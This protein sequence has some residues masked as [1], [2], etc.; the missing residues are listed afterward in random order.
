[1]LKTT[2]KVWHRKF[3]SLRLKEEEELVHFMFTGNIG[4]QKEPNDQ[5]REGRCGSTNAEQTL[6]FKWL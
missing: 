4:E 5:L 3:T 1:M 6:C 2:E